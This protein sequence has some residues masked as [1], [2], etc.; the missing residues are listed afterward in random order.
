MV[1][2][3][4]SLRTSPQEEGVASQLLRLQ[5]QKENILYGSAKTASSALPAG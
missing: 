5:R 2:L 3:I 4:D 1:N